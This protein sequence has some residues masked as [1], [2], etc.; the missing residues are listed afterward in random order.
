VEKKITNGSEVTTTDYL[1]GFH[2]E[3]EVLKFFATSEGYVNVTTSPKQ[4]SEDLV[5]FITT[6][7]IWVTYD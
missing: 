5:T 7:T 1:G 3:N 6:P 2:Y 4:E